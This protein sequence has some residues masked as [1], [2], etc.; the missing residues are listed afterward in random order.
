MVVG[1]DRLMSKSGVV[2]RSACICSRTCCT[3]LT[4]PD[5][6]TLGQHGPSIHGMRVQQGV[7]GR[8]RRT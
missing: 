4:R 1:A 6:A 8:R 2:I 3:C 7:T 5:T